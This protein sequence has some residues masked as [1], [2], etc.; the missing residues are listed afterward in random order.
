MKKIKVMVKKNRIRL[1]EF[2]QDHDVLRKGYVPFMKFKGVLHSQ[3]VNL[4]DEEYEVLIRH[5]A[6]E[7]KKLIN[8]KEFDDAIEKVFVEK[9]LEKAPTKRW[10]EF[11]APSILDPQDVLNNAEEQVLESCL[12]RIGTETKNRRLL[13]K[14]FFQDKVS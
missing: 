1:L 11:K 13:L 5:F 3:N 4:T 2:F 7:D 12:R 10:D 9:N 6:T 8:Y 14:P